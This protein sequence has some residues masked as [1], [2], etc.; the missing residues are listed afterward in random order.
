M[1]PPHSPPRGSGGA[2]YGN[3]S[4]AEAVAMLRTR[5][6]PFAAYPRSA[7]PTVGIPRALDPVLVAWR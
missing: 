7:P 2:A 3:T 5:Q 1:P 4:L 6:A